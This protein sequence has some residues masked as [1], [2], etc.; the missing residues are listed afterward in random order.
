[1]IALPVTAQQE[2]NSTETAAETLSDSW[3]PEQPVSGAEVFLVIPASAATESAISLS[4][5]AGAVSGCAYKILISS[6]TLFT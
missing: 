2:T 6:K 5:L 3:E 4:D 1:M